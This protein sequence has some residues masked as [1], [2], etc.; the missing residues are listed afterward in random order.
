MKCLVRKGVNKKKNPVRSKF[1][2]SFSGTLV[3]KDP[4]PGVSTCVACST[5]QRWPF[6]FRVSLSGMCSASREPSS[7]RRS[8]CNSTPC[9]SHG[10]YMYVVYPAKKKIVWSKW[11]V[12]APYYFVAYMFPVTFSFQHEQMK[13]ASIPLSLGICHLKHFQRQ[14]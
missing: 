3:Q 7:R 11:L 14:S 2:K 6:Q 5:T 13:C 4:S 12:Y 10:L 9:C 8:H 1:H